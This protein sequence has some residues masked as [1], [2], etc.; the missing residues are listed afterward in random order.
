LSFAI[1]LICLALL[2]T[3]PLAGAAP[4]DTGFF[5][6]GVLYEAGKPNPGKANFEY[7]YDLYDSPTG[8][9]RIA[10]P[11]TN[12]VEVTDGVFTTVIDFGA[13]VFDG[14]QYWLEIGVRPNGGGAAFTPLTPRQ[15]LDCSVAPFVIAPPGRSSG[16]T[17]DSGFKEPPAAGTPGQ[18]EMFFIPVSS[19]FHRPFHK[20]CP[21]HRVAHTEENKERSLC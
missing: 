14:R 21:R 4:L 3:A 5:Y 17:S 9:I 15:H 13:N 20:L 12:N 6:Q 2:A 18:H 10:S 1:S 8:A 7:Y 11:V 16:E 19:S